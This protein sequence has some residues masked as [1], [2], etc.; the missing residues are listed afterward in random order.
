[1]KL[2]T[3]LCAVVY[4]S[5]AIFITAAQAAQHS[6]QPELTSRCN[7]K[8]AHDLEMVPDENFLKIAN[9]I[10]VLSHIVQERPAVNHWLFESTNY[11]NFKRL[12]VQRTDRTNGE[13]TL[14][15]Y[16][17]A[18]PADGKSH[19]DTS[20]WGFFPFKTTGTD[21][22]LT[23]YVV[24]QLSELFAQQNTRTSS[25]L[26]PIV[27]CL[28]TGR[29]SYDTPPQLPQPSRGIPAD[30]NRHRDQAQLRKKDYL[31]EL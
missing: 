12:R 13:T 22:G 28:T 3:I 11:P 25:A 4:A 26:M 16:V 18:I 8:N 21:I 30:D 15:T 6:L 9:L 31:E 1:M 17:M 7:K 19:T 10:A 27:H 5:N 23:P 2:V 20:I 14:A 29:Y 24:I